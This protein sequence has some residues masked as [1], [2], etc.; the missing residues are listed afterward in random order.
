MFNN[1]I[2]ELPTQISSLQKLKHLNLGL[3]WCLVSCFLISSQLFSLFPSLFSFRFFVSF[4][5]VLSR[6]VISY[7]VSS[8]LISR[9][10]SSLLFSSLL[11]SSLLFSS[12]L[13]SSLLSLLFWLFCLFLS[14]L[15][16]LLVFF[17]VSFL[18]MSCLFSSVRL[19][20]L[21]PFFRLFSSPLFA[22]FRLVFHSSPFPSSR[23]FLLLSHFSF[24]ILFW[25]CFS[26]L[27]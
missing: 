14:L 3:V 9:L 27:V 10:F 24:S 15:I 1:Q 26:F 12:L 20:S 25:Y 13:F 17:L 7:L 8:L 18:L 16:L 6:L 4:Y 23:Y 5:S 19:L 21:L 22:S 2:E 11:F